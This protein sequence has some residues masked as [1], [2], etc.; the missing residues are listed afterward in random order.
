M[1]GFLGS[2]MGKIVAVAVGLLL[3]LV[4]VGVALFA[5]DY[6]AEAT[7]TGKN[8]QANPPTVDVET[9]LFGVDRTVEVAK[10]QCFIIEK[11]NFVVYRIRTGQTTIYEAEGGKCIYDTVTG[12]GC[13]TEA[14]N[15][16]LG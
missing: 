4:V 11:G 3:L 13:G 16:F 8:C 14:F 5:S 2:L 7:V 15:S 10:Q 1:L 12:P 9:K 6:G